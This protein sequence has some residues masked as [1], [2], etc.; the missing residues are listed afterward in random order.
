MDLDGKPDT[1][2]G[3]Y[4]RIFRR[5]HQNQVSS[6]P[7]HIPKIGSPSVTIAPLESGPAATRKQ[8]RTEHRV[9]L[10]VRLS[11]GPTPGDLSERK[12]WLIRNIPSEMVSVY[13]KIESAFQGSGIFLVTVP[14]EIWTLLP[15]RDPPVK[16]VAHVSSNNVLPGLERTTQSTLPLRSPRP[17]GKENQPFSHHQRRSI[18]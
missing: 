2:A 9:L 16:F 6:C 1:L 12:K 3:I 10:S 14:V 5:A 7:V 8:A 17:T 4:S 13:I 15:S 11:S 18:G